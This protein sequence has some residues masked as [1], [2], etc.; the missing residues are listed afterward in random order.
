MFTGLIREFATVISYQN[1]FLTLS[2]NYKP[3]IGDS[4]AVNG[5][6]LTVVS[7]NSDAFTVE[8][9]NETSIIGGQYTN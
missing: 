7:L 4:I 6:C 8:L 3:N 5:I 1:N 9:S 2:A